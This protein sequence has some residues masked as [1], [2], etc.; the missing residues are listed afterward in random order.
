MTPGLLRNYIGGAWVAP[1]ATTSQEV[2]NPATG[3]VLAQ[4]PL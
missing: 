4:V 3:E 1:R 2:V